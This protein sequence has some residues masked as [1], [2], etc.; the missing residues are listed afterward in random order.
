MLLGNLALHICSHSHDSANNPTKITNSKAWQSSCQD[1]ANC[2]RSRDDWK[3]KDECN[4]LWNAQ[5]HLDFDY[6]L[7]TFLTDLIRN[8]FNKSCSEIG[9]QH[10]QVLLT[11]SISISI[12]RFF[13]LSSLCSRLIICWRLETHS[14]YEYHAALVAFIYAHIF[15]PTRL[16]N[17]CS[18]SGVCESGLRG[19]SSITAASVVVR[20]A[21]VS[22]SSHQLHILGC[23][24]NN[25]QRFHLEHLPAAGV[26]KIHSAVHRIGGEVILVSRTVAEGSRERKTLESIKL[27]KKECFQ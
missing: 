26:R 5:G 10:T 6:G 1:L 16:W 15:F 13:T 24:F 21:L 11:G 12:M 20:E 19:L 9:W 27:L 4:L 7:T 18:T 14:I 17:Q 3:M 8:S 25:I 2:H 23:I 22:G